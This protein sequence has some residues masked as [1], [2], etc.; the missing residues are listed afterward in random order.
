M[1][2]TDLQITFVDVGCGNMTLIELPDGSVL[3]YD[4]NVTSDNSKRVIGYL[5][6]RLGRGMHISKFIN[7][8]RDADHMRGIELIH[9]EYPIDVIWDSGV[10]G[11]STDTP[12]YRTYMRL[13]RDIGF[14]E[15]EPRK[16]WTFGSAL[17]RCMNSRNDLC[18]D[19]NDQSIVF[20][21]EFATSS[22][23]LAGDTSY[24]PWQN[25]I[26]PS[27]GTDIKSSILLAPHHGS[28]TF[29]DDPNDHKHYYV[30]HMKTISPEMTIISTGPNVHD[31]P[32]SKA[33]ELYENYSTG[34][35]QG[36][37][38]YCTEDKGN[39]R[40]TLK[41]AGGWSLTTNAG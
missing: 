31:L 7:S 15:I 2:G 27:Y 14:L 16:R 11:T 35:N 13:R 24:L 26:L 6:N 33:L 5:R 17:F 41:A 36:N 19:C 28:L 21:V 12:E 32:N 34:S 8:H 22:V 23:I 18:S 29:F 39:I 37:K 9:A 1:G 30:A 20:K 3:L 10:E 25:S 40:L 38:V 4:C